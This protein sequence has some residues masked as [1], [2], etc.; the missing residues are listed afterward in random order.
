MI[1]MD[2]KVCFLFGQ[3]TAPAAVVELVEKAAERHYLELGIRTFVIGSRGNFDSYGAAAI[4]RLKKKYA[5]IMLQL[6][7]AYHPSERSVAL[8]DG[9]DSSYY[10][11]LET[12]PRRLAIIKANQ[13]MVDC[14]DSIICYANSVGNSRKVFEYAMRRRAGEIEIE[15]LRID[16]TGTMSSVQIGSGG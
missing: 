15:N 2:Y 12:V 13:Y 6:L 5:D 7:L 10:P 4:K 1:G 3:S 16:G 14:A 8:S 9:F 11:P